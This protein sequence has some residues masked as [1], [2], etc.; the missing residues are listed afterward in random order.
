MLS[1]F[2]EIM[3]HF[4]FCP[5]CLDILATTQSQQL[6]IR[7]NKGVADEKGTGLEVKSKLDL[8]SNLAVVHLRARN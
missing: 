7:T 4:F 8:N 3:S 6:R 2:C 5:D 1:V